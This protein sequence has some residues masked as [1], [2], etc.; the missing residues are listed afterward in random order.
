MPLFPA[1]RLVKLAIHPQFVLKDS[2]AR[3]ADGEVC[4]DWL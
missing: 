4:I 1:E 2:A 3:G